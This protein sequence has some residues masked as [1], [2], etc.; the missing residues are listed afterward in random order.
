MGGATTFTPNENHLQDDDYD[1][2]DDDNST[3]DNSGFAGAMSSLTGTLSSI[4]EE[5]HQLDVDVEGATDAD[6]TIAVRCESERKQYDDAGEDEGHEFTEIT[7]T[8]PILIDVGDD[9]DDD[10]PAE[11]V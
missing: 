8:V 5:G 9:D 3:E 1:V 6:E 4:P 11:A 7:V 2:E 10:S